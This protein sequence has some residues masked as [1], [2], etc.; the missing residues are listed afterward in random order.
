MMRNDTAFKG[1]EFLVAALAR[2]CRRVSF[3]T[4]AISTAVIGLAARHDCN[5]SNGP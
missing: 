4:F 2:L 5:H 3:E 1:V